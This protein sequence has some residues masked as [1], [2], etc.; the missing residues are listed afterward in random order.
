[1]RG[2]VGWGKGYDVFWVWR[3][4]MEEMEGVFG[5]KKGLWIGVKN[6]GDVG[7]VLEG[8]V[9]LVDGEMVV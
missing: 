4:G 1:M 3:V 6:M 7:V 5:W 9:E 8:L 2:I